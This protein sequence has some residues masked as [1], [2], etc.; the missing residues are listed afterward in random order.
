MTIAAEPGLHNRSNP[1]LP[2]VLLVALVAV[3]VPLFVRMPLTNDAEQ[4]DLQADVVRR[5]GML[6]RDA[7]EMKNLAFDGYKRTP[8]QQKQY[9]R[10]RRKL[11]KV[12]AQRLQPLPNTPQPEY[13]GTPSKTSPIGALD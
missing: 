11:A 6:Y 12:K 8:A 4:Y 2:L 9:L 3:A 7:L 10:L 13:Q 5:G 1:T